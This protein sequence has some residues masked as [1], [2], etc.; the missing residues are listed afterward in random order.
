MTAAELRDVLTQ[1]LRRGEQAALEMEEILARG[2]LLE[3][4]PRA[5]AAY[6]AAHERRE[7]SR[8]FILGLAEGLREEVAQLQSAVAFHEEA[9]KRARARSK[10]MPADKGGSNGD[11]G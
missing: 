1:A 9:A 6:D 10:R 11:V 2:E 5:R 7:E 8:T 4:N 3:T